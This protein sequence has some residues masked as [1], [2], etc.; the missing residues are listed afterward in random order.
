MNVNEYLGR[1]YPAPPCWA[2][3]VDVLQTERGQAVN[4]YKTVNSSI[5]AVAAAF[6]IA[7]H[8]SAHGFAQVAAPV[9]F[10]VVL[11]GK[12]PALGMHHCGVYY[13]GKVLHAHAEGNLYQDLASLRDAYQ[14]IEFWAKP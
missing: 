2:L 1:Q 3:V 9:D 13:Q 5:R 11:M 4:E 10:C 14:V 12:T 7:L 6:R 8:K